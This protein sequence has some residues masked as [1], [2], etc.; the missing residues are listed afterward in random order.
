MNAVFQKKY[1]Q[2][3]DSLFS[4]ELE[5]FTKT[6]F[7]NFIHSLN[8]GFLLAHLRKKKNTITPL[9]VVKRHVNN[10]CFARK[11][12]KSI[13]QQLEKNHF[14]FVAL[15][16]SHANSEANKKLNQRTSDRK[17]YCT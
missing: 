13:S 4:V 1:K 5:T 9:G 17:I 14:V 2:N 11:Q 7:S 12:L 6:P 8:S 15:F 16:I 10:N 3:N